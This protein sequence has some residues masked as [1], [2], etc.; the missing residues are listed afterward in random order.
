MT[1]SNHKV[2]WNTQAL[3]P[4]L[5]ASDCHTQTATSVGHL[6]GCNTQWLQQLSCCMSGCNTPAAA[7]PQLLYQRLQN[8]SSCNN[9]A[10]AMALH[11]ST[12]T[13]IHCDM[14]LHTPYT[15]RACKLPLLT[16]IRWVPTRALAQPSLE[17]QLCIINISYDQHMH[18]IPVETEP[19]LRHK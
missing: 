2:I 18:V 10:A 6:S 3:P 9:Q 7:T 14:M 8:P 12:A 11:N 13:P 15:P 1:A 16:P 19:T 17:T 4:T 5:T